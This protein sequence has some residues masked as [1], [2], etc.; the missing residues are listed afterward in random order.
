MA[1]KKTYNEDFKE[2]VINEVKECGNITKVAD[3]YELPSSTI[4][5]RMKCK[6]DLKPLNKENE[7]TKEHNKL[8]IIAE[9]ELKKGMLNSNIISNYNKQIF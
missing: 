7:L 4:Y 3:A 5:D 1:N 9:I 6:Q 8:N 2:K